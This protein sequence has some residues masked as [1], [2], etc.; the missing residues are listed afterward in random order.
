MNKMVFV[1]ENALFKFTKLKLLKLFSKTLNILTHIFFSKM[2]RQIR[3][4]FP[5]HCEYSVRAARRTNT[6]KL[7][8]HR[9]SQNEKINTFELRIICKFGRRKNERGKNKNKTKW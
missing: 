6:I 3:K 4:G 5:I 9:D 7:D 2:F 1:N 8:F